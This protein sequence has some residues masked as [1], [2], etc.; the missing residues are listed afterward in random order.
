MDS[1]LTNLINNNLDE[2]FVMVRTSVDCYIV[3]L[4]LDYGYIERNQIIID[5]FKRLEK[6]YLANP[7]AKFENHKKEVIDVLVKSYIGK[8]IDNK[9]KDL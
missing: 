1:E 6:N 9:E 3:A 5:V 8:Y 4:S 2:H 7:N